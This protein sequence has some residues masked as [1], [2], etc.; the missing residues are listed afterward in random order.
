MSASRVY[1]SNISLPSLDSLFS[2]EEER[3]DAALEKVQELPLDQ[4]FPF[5][6]HPFQVRDD[7]EMKRMVESVKE[8]GVLTPLIARPRPEGGYEIVAGHRR[9]RACELAGIETLP[10]LVREMDDDTAVIRMV[11]TNCQR[12][13]VSAI[14]KAKAYK[15]KLEA[16]KRRAGRPTKNSAQVGQNFSEA[17]SVE[18]VA[19]D[20]GESRSQVQ[21]YIRLNE[22]IPPLQEMVEENRLKFNPAVELSYLAPEEQQQF[23]E[24]IQSEE[25]TPSLSQAQQLKA[26]SKEKTLDEE[27]LT[28]IMTAR[29]PSVAPREQQVSIPL[30]KLHRYFPAAQNSEQ[31]I[32]QIF[33]VLDAYLKKRQLGQER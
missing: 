5:P 3:R 8:Y 6:N 26:A 11:D 1:G 23:F 2:T 12:E 15:M 18:K 21:R 17:F 4:L 20:A 32:A 19:D 31:M 7:E 30:A 27:K 22:L 10:V 9:K 29:A 14:E 16:I 28:R 25:C 33:R 24:Y 13:N